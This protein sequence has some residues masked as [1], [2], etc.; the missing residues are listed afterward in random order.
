MSNAYV[1]SSAKLVRLM[2]HALQNLVVVAV[3]ILQNTKPMSSKV[4]L[5]KKITITRRVYCGK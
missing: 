4:C 5:G 2:F 3:W 1:E